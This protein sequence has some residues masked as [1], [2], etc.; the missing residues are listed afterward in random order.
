MN[1]FDLDEPLDDQPAGAREDAAFQAALKLR[2]PE[3]AWSERD[4]KIIARVVEH[5]LG[6]EANGA[7]YDSIRELMKQAHSTR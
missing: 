1:S 5:L 3:M 2:K 7:D 4:R 6:V